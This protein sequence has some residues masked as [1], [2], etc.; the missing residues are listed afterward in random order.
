VVLAP[1]NCGSQRLGGMV[2]PTVS[3][4]LLCNVEKIGTQPT[5][6]KMP[7]SFELSIPHV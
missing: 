7:F 2:A 6:F 3:G 5:S 1:Y 4:F